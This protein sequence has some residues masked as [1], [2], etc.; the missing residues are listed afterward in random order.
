MIDEPQPEGILADGLQ[1]HRAGNLV[2]ADQA[3]RRC[4][5]AEPEHPQA[6]AFLANILAQGGS[7][8]LAIEY[9]SRA[10]RK[11]PYLVEARFILGVGLLGLKH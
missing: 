5:S 6:L 8:Q 4:L 3:Y 9:S 10:L 11:A 7:F 2:L 1:Q